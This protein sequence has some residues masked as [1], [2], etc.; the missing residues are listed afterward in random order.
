MIKIDIIKSSR[1]QSMKEDIE[2]WIKSHPTAKIQS[3][4]HFSSGGA[5][6]TSLLY[7]E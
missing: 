4:S 1:P 6:W 3:V 5:L 2:N 7:E